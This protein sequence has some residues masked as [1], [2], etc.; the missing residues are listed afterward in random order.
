MADWLQS[1]NDIKATIDFCIVQFPYLLVY[2]T[3]GLDQTFFYGPLQG[4]LVWE[5]PNTDKPAH[6]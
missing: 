3:A 1:P 6:K 5:K 4:A 2:V